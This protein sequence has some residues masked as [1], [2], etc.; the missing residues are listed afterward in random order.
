MEEQDKFLEILGE[1]KNIAA[2]QQNIL[3]KDEIQK[4]LSDM[5][6]SDDKMDAICSYLVAGGIKIDGYNKASGTVTGKTGN[7]RGSNIKHTAQVSGSLGTDSNETERALF[8]RKIYMQEVNSLGTSGISE[9]N[10]II[11]GFLMGDTSLRDKLAE[12]KL[13]H[14]IKLASG[15]KKREAVVNKTISID[16]I[17][18]EGNLGLLVGISIIEENREQYL[19]KD[20]TPD[21][22]AVHGTINMEI[23]SAIETFIDMESEDKDWENAVLAKINLLHEASKH[24]AGEYGSIPTKEEL[25]EYT[26]IP[27]EEIN[28]IMN[29]SE[30]TKRVASS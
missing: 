11:K 2:L 14:V 25:S 8:N 4:Y 12:N 10:N 21:Y 19:K 27:V 15:Y 7:G 28:S 6:L 23:L 3:S 1:I 26:K 24:L 16:E 9:V 29:I 30:D 13:S 5:E 17:I 18:A 20:G 22:E